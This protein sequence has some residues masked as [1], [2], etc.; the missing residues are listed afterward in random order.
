MLSVDVTLPE[1]VV[2]PFILPANFSYKYMHLLGSGAFGLVVSALDINTNK[3][4]AIKKV[5]NAVTDEDNGPRITREI[6]MMHHL[7]HPNII[8]VVGSYGATG[9]ETFDDIYMV[10]DFMQ[11]DLFKVIHSTKQILTFDHVCFLMFQMVKGLIHIHSA[12]IVHRDIKPSNILI[13]QDC[14]IKIADFGLARSFYTQNPKE[15]KNHI[16]RFTEYTV[17][18][19]YRAPEVMC[20]SNYDEK[21]DIWSL[22][23]IFGE[24][25]GR[26]VMFPG[27][28]YIHQ[29]KLILEVIGTPDD[30]DL[31]QIEN[32]KARAFVSSLKRR[33]KVP[34]SLIYTMAPP[35]AIDLL[36]KML[37]FNPKKRISAEDAYLHPYFKQLRETDTSLGLD[38]TENIFYETSFPE[39]GLKYN[40]LR[41]HFS[42]LHSLA[43][44]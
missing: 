36:E 14:T 25:F 18:R 31:D 42:S 38:A 21:I 5:K 4:M 43:A 19:W 10:M 32:K 1:G 16:E 35:E 11:T 40:A 9:P 41:K 26:K 27:C 17:T 44:F 13:N 20:C 12:G 2:E 6:R 23:C 24:L 8:N 37:A 39:G 34:L 30:D 33:K 22:G 15:E 3:L 7:N 28:D 29:M